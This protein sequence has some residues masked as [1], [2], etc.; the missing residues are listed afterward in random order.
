MSP[1]TGLDP[2]QIIEMR[3]LL[4][5]LR[6]THTI[7][8]SSHI[9]TEISETCDRIFVLREGEIVA[10]GKEADL[11]RNMLR[12]MEIEITVRTHGSVGK[13]QVKG[14]LG[15]A[16]GIS[17]VE[18]I[19]PR[20]AGADVASF[21]IGAERDVREAVSRVLV[22]AKVGI[23]EIVRGRKE[24]ESVFLRLTGSDAAAGR[25]AHVEASG[26]GGTVS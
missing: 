15:Q 12:G 6:A 22:E 24:L 19:E 5:E 18:A 21:R 23:L 9:L 20:E 7:V 3:Q 13:E 26:H 1:C 14:I 25:S 17:S 2:A 10:S 11:T 4:R 16:D 8:L